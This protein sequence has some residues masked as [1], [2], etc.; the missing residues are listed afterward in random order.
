M[1]IWNTG[2][3]KPVLEF[4]FEN[5]RPGCRYKSDTN[6]TLDLLSNETPCHFVESV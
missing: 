4:A 3:E 5:V 1:K 2:E 6:V